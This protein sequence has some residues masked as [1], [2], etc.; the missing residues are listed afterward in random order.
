M[1]YT[2]ADKPRPRGEVCLRGSNIFLG[3]YKD[4]EKTAE[5]LTSDGWFYTGDI[6]AWNPDGTLSIIDRKKNIFKLS[7]GE[8][9]A[10][11]K[12]ENVYAKSPFVAQI[13]LYGDSYQSCVVA[14]VVPDPE[15]VQSWATSQG[16]PEGNNLAKMVARPELKAAIVTSMDQAAKEGKLNGFECVKDIHL[17]PDVFSVENDLITPTFKLR[18]PQLKAYFKNQ[19]DTMYAGL[20]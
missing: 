15:V 18:R 19:I 16:I 9:I 20:K 17:H 4:A 10:A 6:G 12:I 1:N 3:Y 14:I 5:C 11:E 2:T 8:Y 7:Q 13:F